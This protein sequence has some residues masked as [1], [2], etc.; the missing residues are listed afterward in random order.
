MRGLKNSKHPHSR[1]QLGLVWTRGGIKIL[2]SGFLGA[3]DEG[4]SILPEV[5]I[6]TIFE[7]QSAPSLHKAPP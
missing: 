4:S 2:E 5:N 6:V 7:N 1:P 3:L